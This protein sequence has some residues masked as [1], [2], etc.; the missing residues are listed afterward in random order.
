MCVLTEKNFV[1]SL[2]NLAL[3][4]SQLCYSE[5]NCFLTLHS[6]A[7]MK[8]NYVEVSPLSLVDIPKFYSS[9]WIV[10][11]AVRD[12]VLQCRKI[13]LWQLASSFGLDDWLQFIL[14]H[15]PFHRTGHCWFA[16]F[17][18]ACWDCRA[19]LSFSYWQMVRPR[20]PSDF[21]VYELSIPW[22]VSCSM[23]KS[24][25]SVLVWTLHGGFL[26]QKSFSSHI[27]S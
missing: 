8:S 24:N 2:R 14:W 21:E 1:L 17:S 15:L 20:I 25:V 18:W 9:L 4:L 11:W 5:T 26:T 16:P 12:R 27:S 7:E 23:A 10:Y 19:H 3:L 6:L 22:T 13:A